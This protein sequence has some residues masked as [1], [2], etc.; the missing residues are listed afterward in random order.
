M[1]AAWFCPVV[2]VAAS[3]TYSAEASAFPDCAAPVRISGAKVVRVERNGVLVLKDGRAV[4][5]EGLL[6]P[7]STPDRA[8]EFLAREAVEELSGL[9][10]GRTV[11]LAVRPPDE[12]RYGHIRAQ[13]FVPDGKSNLWL[14]AAMLRRGLARVSI[15][16]DRREC[17]RELYAAEG[18][19][20]EIRAGIWALPA[21][22]VRLPDSLKS[23]IG[24][25]QIVEGTV[26]NAAVRSGRAYLNFGDDWRTDFTVTIAP[27]DIRLFREE[28]IDPVGYAGQRVRV[29][30]WVQ[31]LNGPEIEIADPE[32]IEIVSPKH[33]Q[34]GPD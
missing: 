7:K 16:P 23:D 10:R 15:A 6:L 27:E 21:Y 30:G 24:T 9:A 8:P 1:R 34:K 31:F 18:E 22:A 2:L 29:R 17:A 19:A 26:K 33:E 28:G 5:V 14:Q 25:F 3:I 13:V 32:A 4:D 11:S 12:D 20:R